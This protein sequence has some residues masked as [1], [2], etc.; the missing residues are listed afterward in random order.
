MTQVPPPLVLHE[1]TEKPFP[2]SDLTFDYCPTSRAY[3]DAVGPILSSRGCL[4]FR[5]SRCNQLR[6][7]RVRIAIQRA[8]KSP[9][10]GAILVN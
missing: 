5:L 4:M 2:E 3:V 1:E 6:W 9:H 10:L 8:S 7:T